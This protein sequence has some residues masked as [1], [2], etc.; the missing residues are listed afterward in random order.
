[1]W[2]DAD[3]LARITYNSV[4]PIVIIITKPRGTIFKRGLLCLL[5]LRF[6]FGCPFRSL[7]KGIYNRFAQIML[8]IFDIDFYFMA[9]YCL[10]RIL[11]NQESIHLS[12]KINFTQ[13]EGKM[14]KCV[15]SSGFKPKFIHAIG[16]LLLLCFFPQSSY[17]AT[18]KGEPRYG[19]TTCTDNLS[20]VFSLL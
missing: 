18:F 17:N 6:G 12:G 2:L 3:P 13:I 11:I 8:N 14:K 4:D 9:F 16:I 20:T 19:R 5:L 15:R 10:P 7:I 1:M